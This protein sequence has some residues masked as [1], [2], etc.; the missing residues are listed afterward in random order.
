MGSVRSYEFL[1][2]PRL[3]GVIHNSRF[4]NSKYSLFIFLNPVIH[5]SLF[6]ARG[7]EETRTTA[8]GLR[9]ESCVEEVVEG[10][11][12]TISNVLNYTTIALFM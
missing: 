2:T 1:I 8:R 11:A 4:S 10:T 3:D 7:S 6:A 9:Q 5:Y 12:S